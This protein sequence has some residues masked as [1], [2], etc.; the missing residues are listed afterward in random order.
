MSFKVH[1]LCSHL[2]YFPPTLAGFSH[3]RGERFH[4]NM[5]KMQKRYEKK[6]TKKGKVFHV[7]N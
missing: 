7:L 3:E 2:E 5:K 6:A 4:Q 1:F